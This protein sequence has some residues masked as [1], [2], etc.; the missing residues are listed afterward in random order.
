MEI[1]AEKRALIGC[2]LS[3]AG[4]IMEDFSPELATKLPD[5]SAEIRQ[6][7]ERLAHHADAQF[8]LAAAARSLL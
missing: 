6:R 3:Q 5:D 2:L 4:R 7:I 1:D 8:A